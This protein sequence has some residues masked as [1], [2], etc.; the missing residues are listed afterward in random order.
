[1]SL[2]IPGFDGQYRQHGSDDEQPDVISQG[3]YSQSR[4]IP[5]PTP[6]ACPDVQL[7][8]LVCHQTNDLKL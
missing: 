7:R 5:H 4:L 1:M 6:H 3:M 2:S 8:P